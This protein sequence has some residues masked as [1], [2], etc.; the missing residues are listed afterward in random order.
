MAGHNK[1]SKVKHI[2]KKVDKKRSKLFSKLTR[3]I[4]V[5]IKEGGDDPDDNPR[6]QNAIDN[7]KGNNMP[8]KNIKRAIKRAS[9]GAGEDL[10]EAMYEGYGPE[11][12][13]MVIECTT[14]NINRTVSNIRHVLESYG[15]SLGDK[16]SVRYLFERKGIFSVPKSQLDGQDTDE[17]LLQLIDAGAEEVDTDT[18]P[19]I[20]TTPKS[21]F[22][23][24]KKAL[25]KLSLKTQ[26]TSL[27]YVPKDSTTHQVPD[28]IAKKV[29]KLIEDLEDDDDV[30]NVYHNMEIPDSLVAELT[31]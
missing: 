6:L 7:A 30:Q 8:K 11:G 2:K 29:L 13:A 4:M 12:I 22:G 24:M 18:D 1:W 9:E 14:D 25:N 15:G 5:A 28:K 19:I 17:L 10:F 31:E 3:E 26:D 20:I 27:E 21:A 23:E 16:G